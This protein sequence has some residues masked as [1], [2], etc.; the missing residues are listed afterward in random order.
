MAVFNSFGADKDSLLENT[1][2]DGLK[3]TSLHMASDFKV[4]KWLLSNHTTPWKYIRIENANRENPLYRSNARKVELILSCV[5]RVEFLPKSED[6]CSKEDYTHIASTTCYLDNA[7]ENH[8]DKC[9]PLFY[10]N[11]QD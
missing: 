1:V 11:V 8:K 6:E 10:C 9:S 4:I 3:N 2:N 5:S 7:S